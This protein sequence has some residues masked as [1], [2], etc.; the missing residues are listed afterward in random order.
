MDFKGGL[1]GV[2]T[3]GGPGVCWD[4]SWG[5]GRGRPWIL[6]V[7]VRVRGQDWPTRPPRDPRRHLWGVQTGSRGR[8]IQGSPHTMPGI[9]RAFPP[10]P[11]ALGWGTR[12]LS[13]VKKLHSWPRG[14]WLVLPSGGQCP[15]PSNEANT[16]ND[17]P[18]PPTMLSWGPA[19]SRVGGGSVN[20]GASGW[21]GAGRATA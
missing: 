1:H 13:Q 5:S 21:R 14:L 18:P 19:G 6:S 2:G 12:H 10:G 17:P 11:G 3:L 7:R 15:R 4:S 20:W 16:L 9:P 8:G